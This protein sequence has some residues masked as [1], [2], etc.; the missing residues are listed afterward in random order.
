[1]ARLVLPPILCATFLLV[2][3]TRTLATSTMQM[4][5]ERPPQ[6][7]RGESIDVDDA[8]SGAR[9]LAHFG[10]HNR[11]YQLL[12]HRPS[13]EPMDVQVERFEARLLVEL[14]RNDRADS[15]L[16]LQPYTGNIRFYYTLCL[17]RARLNFNA[18]RFEHA[19][20]F[21]SLID[22][23]ELP[24]F[25]PYSDFLR[26]Q[27]LM[28]LGRFDEAAS[29]G[30]RRLSRGIPTSLSP[31][32]E[33][34]LLNAYMENANYEKALKF[35]EVLK[36]RRK[37]TSELASL[38]IGEIDLRF[39]LGDTASAI[40]R[41]I[42][43]IDDRH[44]R[45]MA[46]QAAEKLVAAVSLVRFSDEALLVLC[47]VFLSAGRLREADEL[48]TV[49]MERPLDHN[50]KERRRLYRASLYYKEKRYSKSHNL[51]ATR[52]DNPSLQRT[53]MLL[54]ARIYRKTG[55]VDRSADAYVYFATTFPYDSKAAEAL[56][57]AS[58]L[59]LHSS[60]RTKAMD[61]LSR[62]IE[63]Y[64]SSRYGR[65]ATLQTAFYYI[66]RRHYSRGVAI[67]EK[68]LE[69]RGRSSED[70]LYYLADVY[71]RMGKYEKQRKL[72]AELAGLD[73]DSFYLNPTV[74]RDFRQP[75][76][77]SKGSIA[78]YGEGGLLEFLKMVFEQRE[79]AY[80]QIRQFLDPI[81]ENSALDAEALYLE[82]GRQFLQM[83]FRDWAETELQTLERNR[84]LPTRAIFELGVLYDDYAMHWKSVRTFQKVY[85]SLN[86]R[87]RE[88]LDAFFKIL[89]Y[90]VP[91]PALVFENCARYGMPPHL[92][93]AM[94]RRESLFDRDAVSR[95]GAMGLM[96]LMPAT[97][98]QVANELG[99]P[100]GVQKNLLAPEI[101]LT[102]GV[103]YASHLLERSND[104]PLM[105]L[106]AYNAG[107]G[108]ARRWFLSGAPSR[109]IVSTVDGIS[110][111]ETREYVKRIVEGAA[112]YH[113]Y[114]FGSGGFLH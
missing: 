35:L 4:L 92:V 32:F 67:L 41:G 105:M 51:L 103:W 110:Y 114:Y 83:G 38:L 17:Q 39:A 15:L 47:D 71:G 107:F 10:E 108:N 91:Y 52:F 112:V 87:E 85:Y 99:F 97:G 79:R 76:M 96:Q 113:H 21:L 101:N 40:E 31:H 80:S 26:L 36:I 109:D 75:L 58:D 59:Y 60:D 56:Y 90:P 37:K 62:I 49:L 64:P 43:F 1:M 61:I 29:V 28:E 74:K 19:L 9:L 111:R 63:T 27:C 55:Q 48:I 73:P 53:A 82:R 18:G 57:V 66:D 8:W 34:E 104:D 65:M 84:R 11:A 12:S 78:L 22:K 5:V 2:G 89:M 23:V 24:A 93:Y 46:T 3:A 106:S 77:D 50:G 25:E 102:F 44:T 86:Q 68:S 70:L 98:A 20:A 13:N 88:Q 7:L 14:G 94:M 100:D 33:E 72:L 30:E 6:S 54:Q 45:H 16:A 42:E 81:K 95:A 69:R